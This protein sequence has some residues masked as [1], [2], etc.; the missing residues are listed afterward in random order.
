[1]S[2]TPSTNF[3]PSFDYNDY[4]RRL[5]AFPESPILWL[6]PSRIPLAK[7]S[8]LVSRTGVGKSQSTKAQEACFLGYAY[9]SDPLP[10]TTPQI[11]R[12]TP[13]KRASTR[14]PFVHL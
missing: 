12:K 9:E 10:R 2:T 3:R 14:K 7:I 8:L 1:M 11:A 4:L 6:W 13:P 5:D